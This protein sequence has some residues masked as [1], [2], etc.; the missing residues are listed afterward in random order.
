MILSAAVFRYCRFF[1]LCQ[2]YVWSM[3]VFLV[4]IEWLVCPIYTSHLQWI[5]KIPGVFN[6]KSSW[7]WQRRLEVFLGVSPIHLIVYLDSVLL[8][9]LQVFC[10]N[11]KS[12]AVQIWGFV[13]LGWEY[14]VS[15]NHCNHVELGWEHSVSV[16]HCN[17]LVWTWFLE[18]PVHL[19]GCHSHTKLSLSVP[20]F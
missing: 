18:T 11:G 2:P 3:S 6:P 4:S 13:E 20:Q 19:E 8:S 17:R 12:A 7:T 16:N 9:H 1:W 10:A 14:S 15:V 5:V